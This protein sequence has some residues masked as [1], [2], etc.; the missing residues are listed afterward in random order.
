MKAQRVGALRA[1][2][3]ISSY[4]VFRVSSS[5]HARNPSG[6][7]TFS[8]FST[9]FQ[10][11]LPPLVTFRLVHSCREASFLGKPVENIFWGPKVN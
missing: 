7:V 8:V 6:V 11:T 1:R 3:L 10:P 5:P 9:S 4:A 2:T